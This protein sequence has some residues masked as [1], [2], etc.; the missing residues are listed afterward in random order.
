MLADLFLE[1]NLEIS[2][3]KLKQILSEVP[4]TKETHNESFWIY[5]F[6]GGILTLPYTKLI[7]ELEILEI[8]VGVNDK[9]NAIDLKIKTKNGI[10]YKSMSIENGNPVIKDKDIN[11]FNGVEI[12]KIR[13]D[14]ELDLDNATQGSVEELFKN[15]KEIYN[16]YETNNLKL[17][18]K[19]EALH[20]AL[21]YGY[22]KMDTEYVCLI[23][24]G[25]GLGVADLVIRVNDVPIIVEC[26][27]ENKTTQ[28]AMQ[29]IENRG[30]HYLNILGKPNSIFLVGVNFNQKKGK[31]LM[32]KK[33]EVLKPEGLINVL[34]KKETVADELEEKL[35][36]ELESLCYTKNMGI[37]RGESDHQNKH[38]G[39]FTALILG[40]ALQYCGQNDG[41]HV[42]NINVTKSDKSKSLDTGFSIGDDVKFSITE[43]TD[44]GSVATPEHNGCESPGSEDSD[45]QKRCNIE[46]KIIKGKEEFKYKIEFPHEDC[47]KVKINCCANLHHSEE[48]RPK[49]SRSTRNSNPQYSPARSDDESS[50]QGSSK[51]FDIELKEIKSI[52][53]NALIKNNKWSDLQQILENCRD[54]IDSESNL[55]LLLKGIFMDAGI[56][57]GKRVIAETEVS[58]GQAGNIDLLVKLPDG[59]GITFECKFCETKEEIEVK[60]EEANSQLE[61]YT[62]NGTLKYILEGQQCKKV[63]VVFCAGGPVCDISCPEI[64]EKTSIC[65]SKLS[66]NSNDSGFI[67]E[68]SNTSIDSGCI[69][70]GSNTQSEMSPEKSIDDIQISPAHSSH[71]KRK[72]SQVPA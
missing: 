22:L 63:A 38:A 32:V 16:Y 10:V 19:P 53:L 48:L 37:C 70:A 59:S 71:T 31:D 11:S 56:E 41:Y 14:L 23:E 27:V 51:S 42:Q 40:Q 67:S 30:Y 57:G 24:F 46:I 54:F 72:L 55:Q 26:K 44:S 52:D 28:D 49:S 64:A 25:A 69:S 3:Q 15:L 50:S 36:K 7:A 47:D 43:F 5:F 12:R 1:K 9:Q 45:K 66:I 39:S 65:S 4:N 33:H 2:N 68:D 18:E 17:K 21:I 6:L 29:Q 13:Q 62:S 61:G 58:A 35:R 20:K 8:L 60:Q 34:M